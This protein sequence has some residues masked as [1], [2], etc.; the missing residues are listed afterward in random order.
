[1]DLW[2][3]VLADHANIAE[4]CTEVMRATESGPNG[5]AS[6]FDELET[7]LER[8]IAVKESVL[9]PA[10]ARDERTRRDL[11]DLRKEQQELHRQLRELASAP[12]KDSRQWAMDFK[13][14]MSRIE[15]YF[16]LEENGVLTVA[17]GIIPP[18]QQ[19]ALRHAYEREKIAMMES[20]SWHLPAAL[21]PSRYGLSSGLVFGL[22]A[23]AAAIGGA[24]A[25][26]LSRSGASSR[27]APLRAVRRRPEAPFPLRSRVASLDQTHGAL[28]EGS[29]HERME[30][31]GSSDAD[32][33]MRRT[34]DREETDH[35]FSSANPPRAPSGI[36]SNLQPS[37]MVPGT[38]P[39]ASVG[40]IGTGGGSTENRETGSLRRDGR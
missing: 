29:D 16:T 3:M 21:M 25:L 39:G 34:E 27:R 31:E 1:M 35:W 36:S 28:G 24:A 7:E 8:H 37:G 22:L 38:A 30:S 19:E 2:R 12:R 10:L 40:S 13:D 17:R 33:A 20:R 5:R 9:Y 26:W 6:L 15:L 14:F 11:E 32:L 4:L 18:P 23:G